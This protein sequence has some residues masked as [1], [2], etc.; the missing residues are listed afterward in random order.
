MLIAA[1]NRGDRHHRWAVQHIVAARE[2]RTALIV[3]E[4][5]VG[6]AF[7]KL[8]YDKRVSPRRDAGPALRVF[9]MVDENPDAF[10]TLAMSSTAYGPVRSIL[11]KYRDHAFSFVDAVIFHMVDH[12]RSIARVLTVDGMDFRSYR[13]ARPVDVVTP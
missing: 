13:F 9:A 4:P 12:H 5:V 2:T 7:T 11:E 10:R 8:R 3:P 1:I 6:E